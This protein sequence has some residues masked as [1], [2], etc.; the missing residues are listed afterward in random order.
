MSSDKCK[1]EK[2]KHAA[3][4]AY[5]EPSFLLK[6]LMWTYWVALECIKVIYSYAYFVINDCNVW[7]NLTIFTHHLTNDGQTFQKYCKTQL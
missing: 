5:L 1:L 7:Y 3:F 4:W 2:A 6:C